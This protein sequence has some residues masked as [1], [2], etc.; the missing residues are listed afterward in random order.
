MLIRGSKFL[1]SYKP[2]SEVKSLPAYVLGLFKSRAQVECDQGDE[3]EQNG[4]GG[5]KDHKTLLDI[6][7]NDEAR[8]RPCDGIGQ[9]DRNRPNKGCPQTAMQDIGLCDTQYDS[10]DSRTVDDSGCIGAGAEERTTQP[11]ADS[12]SRARGNN[13][14]DID[15]LALAKG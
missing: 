5:A 12:Q 14:S 6:F 11:N 2:A 8:D 4:T 10:R 7:L 13:P 15:R 9:R 1:L 3:L